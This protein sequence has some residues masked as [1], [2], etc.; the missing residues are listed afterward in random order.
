MCMNPALDESLIIL[1]ITRSTFLAFSLGI[2]QI[3][4]PYIVEHPSD[5]YVVRNEPATLNCKAEGRP[6][7]IITWYRDRQLVTTSNENS[8]SHRMV[9]PSGQLFI[10]KVSHKNNKLDKT[11]KQPDVGEYYCNATN[12]ETR[13][14]SISKMAKLEVAGQKGHRFFDLAKLS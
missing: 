14:S 13:V 8:A 4:D 9:L 6:P 3:S 7:P 10:M 1:T 2:Q 11:D 12:P 5:L